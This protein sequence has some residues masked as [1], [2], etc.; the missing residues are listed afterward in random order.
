MHIQ[1]IVTDLDDTLFDGDGRIS[2]YTLSVMRRCVER[3]IRVIPASGRAQA[4][5]EPFVRQLDTGVPYIACNGAQLV[6]ADHKVMQTHF[7]DAALARE[8]CAFLEQNGCYVQAYRNECFYYAEECDPAKSY[9][10]S[11]GMKGVA[12]GDLVRFL[13]FP[14]PKLLSVNHPQ[15]IA[16]L[17]PVACER[18]QGRVTFTVSKPYFLEAEPPGVSKGAALKELARQIDIDPQTTLAFGDSLNDVTMLAFTP[19]SVAMGNARD[20]VKKAAAYVCGSNTQDGLAKFIEQ[21]VLYEGEGH[22]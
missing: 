17:Y 9:K 15:E 22:P 12:V 19:N 16:T 21:H 13:T 1:T 14:V 10:K 6:S 11:S 8:V 2:D 5:M 3:G 7:L 18:F 20:E 4:S